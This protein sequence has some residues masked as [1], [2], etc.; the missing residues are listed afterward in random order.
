MKIFDCHC[1]LRHPVSTDNCTPEAGLAAMAAAGISGGNVFSGD[2]KCFSRTPETHPDCE[3]R[4]ADLLAYTSISPDLHPLF[5]IDPTE[6][7]AIEQARYAAA[8]GVEGFK[9]IVTGYYPGDARARPVYKEIAKLGKPIMFH[10]GILYDGLDSSKYNRP[11]EFECL[12]EVPGLTFSLAHLSWPWVDECIAVFGKFS[13]AAEHRGD[14]GV[15]M[16]LD[17]CP[18]TPE[19]YR[20][21]ALTMVLGFEYDT[22]QRMMFGV[23]SYF[24]AYGTDYAAKI[25]ANDQRIMAKLGIDSRAQERIFSGNLMTFLGC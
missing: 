2:P 18:G 6:P 20:E 11:S 9:I 19:I 22:T 12:L 3:K 24:N 21:Y 10:S 5:F 23:D 17:N 14:N 15:R 1:H 8:Q 7:D 16:F 25:L 13:S 4:V